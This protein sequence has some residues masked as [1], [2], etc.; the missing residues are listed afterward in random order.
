MMQVIH[1][2]TKQPMWIVRV[3]RAALVLLIAAWAPAGVAQV[4]ATLT[5]GVH[6][7][8]GPDIFYPSVMILPP[9]AGVQVFGCM[10]GFSWC[11][12]GFGFN[13]GW[14]D[15]AFLQAPGPAGPV[16][17]A[18]SPAMVGVPFVTF[19]FNNY[20]N[21]WYVGRPWYGRR[22]FYYNHWNRFPNGRP[23]PIYRPRPPPPVFRPPPGRPP[24]V[25]PPPRPPP[26]TRPPAGGRPPGA[27]QPPPGNRPPPSNRPPPRQGQ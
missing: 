24:A 13:R 23:P 8:A 18:S 12:V 10:P 3:S 15:A 19:S 11:D 2:T 14:V 6:L 9:G 16:L 20:W 17:I 21:T 22:A 5:A 1:M 26:S 7:R 4:S 25:R 27:N